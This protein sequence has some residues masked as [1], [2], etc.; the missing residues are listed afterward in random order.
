MISVQSDSTWKLLVMVAVLVL[1][2]CVGIANMVS[3]DWFIERS[4]V[5]KG[6]EMLTEWNRW[7]FRFAGATFTGVTVY[8]LYVFLR[9]Y[10]TK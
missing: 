3:P 5:R 9:G 8:V 1:F 4:G 7:C 2:A 10:L 6:G